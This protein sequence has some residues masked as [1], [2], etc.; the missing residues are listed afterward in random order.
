[1][2]GLFIFALFAA[3]LLPGTTQAEITPTF[4]SGPPQGPTAPG[5][6]ISLDAYVHSTVYIESALAEIGGLQ[7]DLARTSGSEND[8]NFISTWIRNFQ[9][10]DL[11]DGPTNLTVSFFGTGGETAV[12]NF[13]LIIATRPALTVLAPFDNFVIHSGRWLRIQAS[14]HDDDSDVRIDV[15]AGKYNLNRTNIMDVAVPIT[16]TGP[17]SFRARG[18]YNLNTEK[19]VHVIVVSDP[20]LQFIADAPGLIGDVDSTRILYH[21]VAEKKLGIYHLGSGAHEILFQ[22]TNGWVIANANLTPQGVFVLES[23]TGVGYRAF[24]VAA[25]VTTPLGPARAV[26]PQIAGRYAAWVGANNELFRRDLLSQTNLLITNSVGLA[27]A[28]LIS[29]AENGDVTYTEKNTEEI[30]RYRDGAIEQITVGGGFSNW[31]DGTNIVYFINS[32]YR[33]PG[34][35]LLLYTPGGTVSLSGLYDNTPYLNN[36]WAAFTLPSPQ[37]FRQVV[38]APNGALQDRGA[39][40]RSSA[41]NQHGELIIGSGDRKVL[42]RPDGSLLDFGNIPGHPI[43]RHPHWEII[44]GNALFRLPTQNQTLTLQAP[45]TS[46]PNL[47]LRFTGTPGQPYQIQSTSDFI[48]WTNHPAGPQIPGPDGYLQINDPPPSTPIFYRALQEIV[49]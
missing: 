2:K 9:L 7:F 47:H 16:N 39:G 45:S 12:T 11:P 8:G 40:S 37:G 34:N 5:V 1:M 18:N 22:A 27:A 17:I 46:Q 32:E 28:H 43:Y 48:H 25:G 26:A 23:K 19:S 33:G 10:P 20:R 41:L 4:R 15:A 49:P 35:Q 6:I 24:D 13:N 3:L 42:S 44:I 14:A 36:G 38:R 31:T 30:Y 21:Q 29:V